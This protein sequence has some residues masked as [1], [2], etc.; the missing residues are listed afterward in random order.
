MLPTPI[1]VN[2]LAPLLKRYD[3]DKAQYILN[4]FTEGFPIHLENTPISKI[5]YRNHASALSKPGV[6]DAM[7][8]IELNQHRIAGP[9]DRAP[10]PNLVVSPLG[11]REKREPNKFRLIHDLSFNEDFSVNRN[12]PREFCSVSYETLD[13]YCSIIKQCGVGA[14]MAKAD[15]ESAFRLIP[16]HPKNHNLLGFSWKGKLYYDQS[17]PMG[18]SESCRIFETFSTSIQWILQNI[19]QIKWVSH[20]LDDFLFCGP[21][22]THTCYDSLANF[23][24]LCKKVNIPIK[25][26]KTVHPTTL[27]EAHGIEIDSR[28]MEL[29]LPKDKLATCKQLLTNLFNSKRAT[30]LQLQSVLG[31]LNFACKAIV[32]GRAFLRR[33]IHLTLGLTKPHHHV[34]ITEQARADINVWL[35]FLETFN[36]RSLFLNDTWIS[37]STLRMYTDAAGSLGYAAVFGSHWFAHPWQDDLAIREITYKELFP[38]VLA[39]EIWGHLLRNNRIIFRTDN[40][41]VVA[42]IN[43]QTSKDIHVMVLV[44]RLVSSALKFNIQFKAE[45]IYGYTN[46]VA[47]KLS[48]LKF[49]E[50]RNYAPWLDPDQ[51]VI[52]QNTHPQS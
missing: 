22:D 48:R 28:R 1:K 49:Q 15:I 36:G 2:E 43:K 3:H 33:I 19:Y 26:S 37:S 34:R 44:R 10:L 25:H 8:Q 51:T 5:S 13:D 47:D 6:V 40:Q 45:H 32:P 38:I 52:A 4:G 18:L 16:I 30:L 29:R 41:A 35:E 39:L 20:L 24:H 42:I 46:V 27:M 9:F 17:L 23:E 31:H 12:I 50:A 21:K 7:L 11:L 14:L